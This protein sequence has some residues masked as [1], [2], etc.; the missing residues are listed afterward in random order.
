[1][2]PEDLLIMSVLPE[3]DKTIDHSDVSTAIVQGMEHA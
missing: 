3:S 2:I 1:M